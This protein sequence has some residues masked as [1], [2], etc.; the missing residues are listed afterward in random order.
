MGDWDKD[1]TEDDRAADESDAKEFAALRAEAA[2][3]GV[4]LIDLNDPHITGGGH[5]LA[6]LARAKEERPAQK[7]MSKPESK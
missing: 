6:E 5:W 1:F 3:R 7:S 2:K 4:L